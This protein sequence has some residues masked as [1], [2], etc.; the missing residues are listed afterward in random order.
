ML[1]L[2]RLAGAQGPVAARCALA[3]QHAAARGRIRADAAH[4]L[5]PRDPALGRIGASEHRRRRARRAGGQRQRAGLELP[6]R[7]FAAAG[8]VARGRGAVPRRLLVRVMDKLGAWVLQGHRLDARRESSSGAN[9]PPASSA[10]RRARRSCARSRRKSR[11]G[12]RRESRRWRPC[13]RRATAS[14]ASG[15][16]RC[17]MRRSR[18]S[19]RPCRCSMSRGRASSPTRTRRSRRCRA[20]WS[21]NCAISAWR[22]RSWRCSR[23][24]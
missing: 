11:A 19:C 14:S 22:P 10:S 21:S 24:R 16:C 17:S 12:R 4:E 15:R 5:R 1:A 6:R 7:D 9:W 13:P 3:H 18:A 8:P 23:A 20:W 2:C